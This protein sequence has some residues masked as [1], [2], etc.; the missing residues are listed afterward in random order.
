LKTQ[1][2]KLRLKGFVYNYNLLR[3]LRNKLHRKIYSRLQKPHQ[4][5]VLSWSLTQRFTTYFFL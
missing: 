1:I 4:F 2:D 3:K 5:I